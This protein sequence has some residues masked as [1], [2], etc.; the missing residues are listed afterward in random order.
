MSRSSAIPQKQY[1]SYT[2]PPSLAGEPR[3][4]V[5]LVHAPAPRL[6][7]SLALQLRVVAR[8]IALP[9]SPLDT[10]FVFLDLSWLPATG[11]QSS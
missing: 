3:P 7:A 4:G 2:P 1:G 9:P 6:P 5:V 11:V 10:R 8:F